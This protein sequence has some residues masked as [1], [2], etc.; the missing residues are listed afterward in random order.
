L[1]ATICENELPYIQ[2]GFNVLEAGQHTLNLTSINGCDSI[3]TL[4]LTVN[5]T[6]FT[7]LFATICENELPFIQYGFN[8]SEAGMHQRTL[9]SASGC[10]SIVTLDLTVSQS[11]VTE[12]FA[13]FYKG[14]S[15]SDD[16]FTNL[17]AEE[18]H[19]VILQ[20]INGC[21][22]IIH[23]I[24]TEI[25]VTISGKVMHQ[26]QTPLSVGM[27]ELLKQNGTA[28]SMVASVSTA[29]DGT[30]LFDNASVGT[31]LILAKPQNA[32]DGFNTYYQN[33]EHWANATEITI[34]TPVEEINITIIPCPVILTGS[35][36][37]SGYV[38]EKIGASG[39]SP[40]KVIS[41]SQSENP[42]SDVTVYLQTLQEGV[43]LT[44][45]QTTTD[46]NGYFEFNNLPAGQ[47]RVI[48]DIPGL[49][50]IVE[51]P[52]IDLGEGEKV[53]N[54]DYIVTEEGI[55]SDYNTKTDEVFIQELTIYPNPVEGQ[56]RVTSYELQEGV[57]YS[58]FG[59]TGQVLM[60]GKL[61][62]ETT[63]IDV[64]TLPNGVYLIKVGNATGKF[65][66]K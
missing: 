34:D 52:T 30:Y 35:G 55:I 45:A 65:V 17:T 32:E 24:L 15:Y 36:T 31:Y 42:A 66:K 28:Y 39:V 51:I 16:N 6:L 3:V 14:G 43:W 13:N 29:T 41:E 48:L 40:Q 64:K 63:T 61:S 53:K 27:V 54:V 62:G 20:S 59:V 47:Y 21:D 49:E 7:P 37:I 2:Y 12:Y 50:D 44:V 18:I 19:S 25:P 11:S 60:Q 33:A 8:V 46:E 5:S 10:D 38:S 23:L 22:S 4:D 58:I 9:V 1:F 57:L 56:L 26:N